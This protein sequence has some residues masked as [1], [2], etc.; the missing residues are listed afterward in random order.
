MKHLKTKKF[1]K[2]VLDEISK[3][4]F[5]KNLISITL[6]EE[7]EAYKKNIDS[8]I[9]KKKELDNSSLDNFFKK[10]NKDEKESMINVYPTIKIEENEDE[11]TEIDS[12]EEI[13]AIIDAPIKKMKNFI[14]KDIKS[15]IFKKIE[16]MDNQKKKKKKLAEF[17]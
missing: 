9:S 12:K 1:H 4:R 16:S 10:L 13:E 6:D 8:L 2:F 3:Q 15:L 14:R 17:P 5:T 7:L 11:E